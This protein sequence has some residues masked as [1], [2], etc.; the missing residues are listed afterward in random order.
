MSEVKAAIATVK[1]KLGNADKHN[2]GYQRFSIAEMEAIWG[3]LAKAETEN[4]ALQQKLD[5]LRVLVESEI[6]DFCAGLQ[7]PGEPENPEEMQAELL[8][9]IASV[10]EE[11]K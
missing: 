8:R 9:R 6:A 4:S 2:L 10:F 11:A 7:S 1:E 3:V 5:A